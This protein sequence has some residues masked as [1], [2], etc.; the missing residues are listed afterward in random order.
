MNRNKSNFINMRSKHNLIKSELIKK[1]VDQLTAQ[2][3][4]I[5]AENVK[6]LDISVGRFGDL[7]SYNKSN[8]GYIHGI[9]IDFESIEEAKKRYIQSK[10]QFK[11]LLEVKPISEFETDKADYN[12]VVC[13]FTLHY[14]FKTETMLR[15][16]LNNISCHLKVGGYFIGTTI[17][18][19]LVKKMFP[20]TDNQYFSIT[21]N[22]NNNNNNNYNNNNDVFGIEYSFK[23]KDTDNSGIYSKTDTEY[24][25]NIRVLTKI[26]QEYKLKLVSCLSFK[27]YPFDGILFPWEIQI[28]GLYRQ[29]IFLRIK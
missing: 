7:H 11:C 3:V 29:F 17:D 15:S 19:D 24:L 8:I 9:D 4:V 23:M 28:S 21:S 2:K 13:N 25:T 10:Y 16:V 6:L 1:T 18:G 14:F 20:H 12:I 26:A 5:S 22:N 27:S